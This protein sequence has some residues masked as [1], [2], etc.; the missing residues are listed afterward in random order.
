MARRWQPFALSLCLI[1]LAG[2]AADPA[3]KGSLEESLRA[4][5]QGSVDVTVLNQ[6]GLPVPGATVETAATELVEVDPTGH[7]VLTL[8]LGLHE[9]IA[10]APGHVPASGQVEVTADRV[11]TLALV[12]APAPSDAPYHE[13]TIFRGYTLCDFNAVVAAFSYWEVTGTQD[14]PYCS[15][16]R[17]KFAV[18][19]SEPWRYGVF[20]S[21]WQGAFSMHLV[22][23]DDLTCLGDENPCW[24]WETGR[25]PLRVEGAPQD[26]DLAARYATDGRWMYPDGAFTLN[27]QS[28]SAGDYREEIEGVGHCG[29]FGVGASSGQF[30]DLY[31]SIF[32]HA[33]PQDPAR[34]SALPDA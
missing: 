34:Y 6:E 12:L 26:P 25:A 1:A 21:A 5:G 29:C 30:F 19:V 24:A 13:V 20:E 32:Y 31:I 8:P 4:R 14:I 3:T 2:C 11:A 10:K 9:V 15:E 28:T 16:A 23:D 33:R 22:V 27:I 7:A 18:N 17:T